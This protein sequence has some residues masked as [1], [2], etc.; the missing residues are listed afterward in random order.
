MKELI[1][2][3][4][5]KPMLSSIQQVYWKIKNNSVV[6]SKFNLDDLPP[7][8]LKCA[9]GYNKYGGYCVPLSSNHR[10]AALKVLAGEVYEPK[11]IEFITTNCADGDIVHAGTY[12]GDFLPALSQFC[13]SDAIIWAFEPNQE[14][15]KCAQVTRS[16]NQLENVT[17]T[18]AGLGERQE[19]LHMIVRDDQG[20]GLGGASKVVS[21][22]SVGEFAS[23]NMQIVEIVSIDEVVPKNRVVS[24]IQLDVEGFEKQALSGALSTIRRCLPIIV[25]EVLEESQLLSSKWFQDNILSLG[26]KEKEVIE[27][28]Y[29]FICDQ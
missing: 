14:S 26:Y 4:T 16:I 17:L 9:F 22:E 21:E 27:H 1:K 2:L 19:T 12:L 25:V 13:G 18:N 8:T 5:P 24:I 23:K 6:E 7:K 28:N 20:K 29:I 11:T 3:I 15:F 10:P